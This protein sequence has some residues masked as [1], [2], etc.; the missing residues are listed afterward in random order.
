MQTQ[1]PHIDTCKRFV[2]AVDAEAIW[3]SPRSVVWVFENPGLCV[4]LNIAEDCDTLVTDV[5]VHDV[6]RF[7]GAVR[8]MMLRTLLVIN[9]QMAQHGNYALA[10][11]NRSYVVL[12][13]RLLLASD[14]ADALEPDTYRACLDVWM[15][16]AVQLREILQAIAM[17]NVALGYRVDSTAATTQEA[18]S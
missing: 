15:N 7:H 11:D 14:S 5:Y 17:E 16:A 12:S 3:D 1:Q 8:H 13:G 6:A 4:R 18:A 2:A 9:E 10:V